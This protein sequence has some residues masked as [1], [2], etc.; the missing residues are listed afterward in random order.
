LGSSWKKITGPPP[1]QEK[2]RDHNAREW[3]ILSA[4]KVGNFQTLMN[5]PSQILLYFQGKSGGSAH[6][7]IEKNFNFLVNFQSFISVQ[8]FGIN[9][10]F[11]K[12][13]SIFLV[14]FQN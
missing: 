11:N 14:N 1:K 6:F 9:G 13:R 3:L 7:L 2:K 5:V 12:F 10:F 4:L 8:V